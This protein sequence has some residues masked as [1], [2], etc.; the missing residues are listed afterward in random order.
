VGDLRLDPNW[1]TLSCGESCVRLT[2]LEHSI[3]Q[4]LAIHAGQVVT[5]QNLIERVWGYKGEATSHVAKG[6]VRSLRAKMAEIGSK[7]TVRVFPGF[8]YSLDCG[9]ESGLQHATA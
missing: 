4:V 8:G 6:H 7:T 9:L 2:R 1:R 5:H 3:L